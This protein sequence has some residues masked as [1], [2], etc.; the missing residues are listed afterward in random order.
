VILPAQNVV[1][2]VLTF[3]RPTALAAGLALIRLQVDAVERLTGGRISARIVVVDNDP[4]ASARE[5]V[6]SVGDPSVTYVVEPTPGIAAA[7]NRALDEARFADALVFID[8]D[9]RPLPGWVDS[10]IHTWLETGAAAVAGRVVPVYP[11][12][13]S[14]WIVDGGFFVRRT[15]PTGTRVDAAPTSNILLD[16]AYL[17]RNGLRFDERLGLGGGED[18]MLTRGIVRTGG[19]IVWC[20]E[21]VVE[22][23]VPADR[24]TPR[25]V[26]QRAWSHGNTS[27]NVDLAMAVTARQRVDLRAKAALG[28]SARALLGVARAGFGVVTRSNHHSARGLRAAFRGA[29]MAGAAVGITYHEYAKARRQDRPREAG[30]RRLSEK[31]HSTV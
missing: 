4:D 16:L 13:V 14:P 1:V 24:V 20:D 6:G 2:A 26:L 22:D 10:L 19:E 25:W 29:G 7:R 23:H 31:R 8:D 18:T 27:V 30:R 11:E 15:L 9:E 21:S 28:G 3:R 5:A 12:L 17:A